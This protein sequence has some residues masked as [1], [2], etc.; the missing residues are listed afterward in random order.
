MPGYTM[1]LLSLCTRSTK[2]FVVS[3]DGV[4][5]GKEQIDALRWA[6]TFS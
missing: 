5:E 2:L 6:Y 1:D 4:I 3:F